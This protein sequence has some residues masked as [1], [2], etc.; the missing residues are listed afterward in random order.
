MVPQADPLNVMIAGV[1]GQGNLLASR[2]IGTMLV[3]KGFK[4]TIGETL[5]AT[6]RGGAVHSFLRISKKKN[7]SPQF[8]GGSAHIIIGLEPVEALRNM[9]PHGS[10]ETVAVVNVRPIKPIGV[11]SGNLDYPEIE[12]LK[13]VL[14]E[15]TKRVFFIDATEKALELGKPVFTNMV[16]IGGLVGL[17]VLPLDI[18][19]FQTAFVGLT[20]GSDLELNLEAFQYGEGVVR[21]QSSLE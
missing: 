17:G 3:A 2:L 20:K 10:P 4:V 11:M 8:P 13:Q 5:G 9:G 7:Y 18:N 1:G 21:Q 19:D 16:M 14:K 12:D 6:Q 15:I